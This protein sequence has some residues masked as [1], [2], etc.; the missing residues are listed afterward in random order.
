MESRTGESEG[1]G[2][3]TAG[4]DITS[5]PGVCSAATSS[6]LATWTRRQSYL[7]R[8]P[9]TLAEWQ[10]SSTGP[11]VLCPSTGCPPKLT[12]VTSTLSAASSANRSTRP[13]AFIPV[14]RQF[15]CACCS[16]LMC[17]RLEQRQLLDGNLARWTEGHQ[18]SITLLID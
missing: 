11:L 8:P 14:R 1:R 9:L 2:R 18:G 16:T 6:Q 13:S 17:R 15:L 10:S 12:P 3:M 5:G 4:L 7:L